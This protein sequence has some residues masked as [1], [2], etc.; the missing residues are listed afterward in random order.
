MGICLLAKKTFVDFHVS[1]KYKISNYYLIHLE[2]WLKRNDTSFKFSEELSSSDYVFRYSDSRS[3][4]L[5]GISRMNPWEITNF[6]LGI[7]FFQFSRQVT[8]VKLHEFSMPKQGVFAKRMEVIKEKRLSGLKHSN[9][10]I[11]EAQKNSLINQFMEKVGVEDFNFQ[12]LKDKIE[13]LYNGPGL[14]SNSLGLYYT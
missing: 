7:I 14:V 5:P 1:F 8:L 13:K 10:T 11:V 2:K 12:I 3:W 4:I 9:N 6:K